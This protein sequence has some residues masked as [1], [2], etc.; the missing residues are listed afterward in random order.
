MLM[1]FSFFFTIQC[2]KTASVSEISENIYFE[3]FSWKELRDN[4]EEI[5]TNFIISSVKNMYSTKETSFSSQTS[6]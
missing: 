5:E 2:A 3:G 6:G 1:D 4:E